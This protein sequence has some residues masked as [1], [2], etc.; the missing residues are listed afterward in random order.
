MR[1]I[2]LR[3]VK[4]ACGRVGGFI[5]FH[6]ATTEQYFTIFARKLFHIRRKSNI[7][8]ERIMKLW[9]NN[10][11]KGGGYMEDLQII[12]HIIELC[13]FLFSLFWY[14]QRNSRFIQRQPFK[15]M[16]IVTIFTTILGGVA[17][18]IYD[19]ILFFMEL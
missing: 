13:L 9:Y 4:Y 7:S 2:W 16:A 3:H 12:L 14:S 17:L 6:I 5:S 10:A 15:I 11:K 19:I 1:E 18:G 8:L